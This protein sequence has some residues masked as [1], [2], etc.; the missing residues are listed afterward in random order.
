MPSPPPPRALCTLHW[1]TVGTGSD[2][3]W[4]VQRYVENPLLLDGLKFDL[5][6]Y[7]AVTSFRPLRWVLTLTL[8]SNER[9]RGGFIRPNERC[10]C[11]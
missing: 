4:I 5:R 9:R 3:N 11:C 1:D 7:V 8:T 6:L 2:G 10:T